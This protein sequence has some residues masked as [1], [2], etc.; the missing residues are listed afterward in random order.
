MPPS[1]PP[2]CVPLSGRSTLPTNP[3]H[4]HVL[5]CHDAKP[6]GVE[7]CA[8]YRRDNSQWPA[9]VIYVLIE[10]AISHFSADADSFLAGAIPPQRDSAGQWVV[11]E[12]DDIGWQL[13]TG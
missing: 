13:G 12:I 7:L 4:G 8:L 11:L 3:T 9:S 5:Q 6:E 1:R 2:R 10:P